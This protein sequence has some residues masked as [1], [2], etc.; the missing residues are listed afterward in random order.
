MSAKLRQ[1]KGNNKIESKAAQR[2]QRGAESGV[3]MESMWNQYGV[4]M[5]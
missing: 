4:N 1:M 5:E 3:N 2:L